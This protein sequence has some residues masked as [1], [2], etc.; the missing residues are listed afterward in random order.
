MPSESSINKSFFLLVAEDDTDDIFFLEEALKV[1]CADWQYTFVRNGEEMTSLL[2]SN[3]LI[4][5]QHI[6][7]ILL[8]MNMPKKNGL[9]TLIDIRQMIEYESIPVVGYSTSDDTKM[10]ERFMAL[11][12]NHFLTKPYEPDAFLETVQQLRQLANEVANGV[13]KT[14]GLT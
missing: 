1:E 13:T 6:S 2:E 7:L 9:D 3:K 12:G 14:A 5:T 11:G 8:D 10:I 4:L